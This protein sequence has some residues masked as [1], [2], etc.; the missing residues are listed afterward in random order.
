[1]IWYR[2]LMSSLLVEP[3]DR[4]RVSL[5]RAGDLADR[6]VVHRLGNGVL[7]LEPAV[8]LGARE[9]EELLAA[10]AAA[11]RGTGSSPLD[12]ALDRLDSQLGIS[13]RLD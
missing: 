5:G 1:M 9:M 12:D 2:T 3:D 8:V 4:G 10:R 6:Y 11:S 13:T 7:M